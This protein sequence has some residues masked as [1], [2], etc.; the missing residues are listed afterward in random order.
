MPVARGGST[1]SIEPPQPEPSPTMAAIIQTT[2]IVPSRYLFL[3]LN[4]YFGVCSLGR[5]FIS[6]F[7]SES[8]RLLW[9][10]SIRWF[11]QRLYWWVSIL[12]TLSVRLSLKIRSFWMLISHY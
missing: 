2:I 11:K 7:I 3:N 4:D 10:V 5:S 1:G 8:D 6:I 9:C 12:S